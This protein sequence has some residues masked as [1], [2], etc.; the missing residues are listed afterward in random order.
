M[1]ETVKGA[2]ESDVMKDFKSRVR[3]DVKVSSQTGEA[4]IFVTINNYYVTS[5]SFSQFL[6]SF[7]QI[8]AIFI[9]R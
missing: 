4:E 2:N 1:F 5:D 6:E 9:V 3:F 7:V 8:Y